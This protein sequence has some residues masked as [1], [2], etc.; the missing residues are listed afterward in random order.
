M[1]PR[2]P[3]YF[4]GA[5]YNIVTRIDEKNK[6]LKLFWEYGINPVYRKQEPEKDNTSFHARNYN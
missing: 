1:V 5:T 6:L 3:L 2:E 4:V